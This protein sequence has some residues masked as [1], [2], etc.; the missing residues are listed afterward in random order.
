VKMQPG[1]KSPSPTTA[2][3]TSHNGPATEGL[4]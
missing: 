3:R 1:R 4:K 2:L